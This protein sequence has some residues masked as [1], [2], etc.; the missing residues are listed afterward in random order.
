M[1]QPTLK[2]DRGKKG[3]QKLRSGVYASCFLSHTDQGP[4]V[5]YDVSIGHAGEYADDILNHRALDLKP[6]NVMS[7]ALGN[8]KVTVIPVQKNLCNAHA[9]RQF[10]DIENSFPEQAQWI[11]EQYQKIFQYFEKTQSSSK[12]ARVC[13][14]YHQRYSKPI[15]EKIQQWC[16]QQLLEHGEQH[17]TLAKALQYV[18]NH[19]EGLTAVCQ[20]EHA[21]IDNNAA[22]RALKLIIRNRKSSL[23]CKTE[24]GAHTTN[25]IT[26]IVA[27]CAAQNV[28]AFEYMIWLQQNRVQ[29]KHN[30]DAFTPWVYQKLNSPQ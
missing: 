23:F 8:N 6:P 12:A 30:P 1:C 17:S 24:A 29:V 19:Y 9:Q 20:F 14:R 27:T 3:G 5:L 25:I 16:E 18:L 7:D 13:L 10:I 15:F 26:S 2:P 4:M 21:H 22:E 11:V 28:N